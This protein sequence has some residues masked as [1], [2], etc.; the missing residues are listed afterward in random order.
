MPT[1]KIPGRLDEAHRA[2]ED[3]VELLVTEKLPAERS[4][5]RWTRAQLLSQPCRR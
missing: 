5:R 3:F 4:G 2:Y 1:P